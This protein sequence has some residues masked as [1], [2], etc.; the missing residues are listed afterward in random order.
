MSTTWK[1]LA[2][3]NKQKIEFSDDDDW[4]TDGNFE[5][6]PQWRAYQKLISANLIASSSLLAV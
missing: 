3:S 1:A 2:S 6:S 5:V 4:E